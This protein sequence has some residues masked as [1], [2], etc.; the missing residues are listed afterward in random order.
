MISEENIKKPNFL[1]PGAQKSGSTT[2]H[3]LLK[4]HPEIFLPDFK[5]P[6]YFISD[7]IKNISKNDI[8]FKNEGFKDKL[9]HTYDDYLNLFESVN[10]E[11]AMGEASA[12]Y[13][14][15]FRHSIPLIK[16]KLGDPKI[17][18]ILRNPVNKI[19][20]QYKHLQRE[21]AENRIFEKGLELEN[22]RIEDNFTAM[23]H[24]KAQGMYFEQVKAYKKNF[25]QVLVVFTDELKEDPISVA[26]KCYGFL[27]VDQ[28]FKP[29]LKNYNISAKRVKNPFI[30]NLFF[31]K[32]AHSVKLLFKRNFG[33]S[34]YENYS[35]RYRKHNFESMNLKMNEKTKMELKNY[36]KSDI[37]NLE[38]LLNIELSDWKR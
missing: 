30:H 26:K 34:F 23:Y 5:E 1:I 2:L 20:S 35:N 6:L 24:Y 36:F 27:E 32:S 16:D 17:I 33:D 37:E 18:I 28:S 21:H 7:I 9:I 3:Y 4:Q 15:Y 12:S 14:Y 22:Q 19:F 29:D 8:G 25:S 11:K 10:G 31:N 13:L 38:N